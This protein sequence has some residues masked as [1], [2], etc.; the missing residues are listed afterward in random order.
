MP[1]LAL[2][3]SL[4]RRTAARTPTFETVSPQYLQTIGIPLLAGR[5]LTTADHFDA[6][7]VALINRTLALQYWPDEKA[8]LGQ[9]IYTLGDGNRIAGRMTIVGVVGDV[10]DSPTDARVQPIFYQ[11]FLQYPSFGNF[12]VLRG[13]GD[14]KR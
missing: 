5:W 2:K 10:K 14:W 13:A 3:A 11:S 9:Q 7:K 4:G 12:V 8:S 6:P 1:S